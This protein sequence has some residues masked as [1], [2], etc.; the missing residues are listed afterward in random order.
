MIRRF[1]AI[2]VSVLLLTGCGAQSV[3]ENPADSLELIDAAETEMIT[4]EPAETGITNEIPDET[5]TAPEAAAAD[6]SST[7]KKTSAARTATETVAD[8]SVH[9]PDGQNAEEKPAKKKRKK[10]DLSD[11]GIDY[12]VFTESVESYTEPLKGKWFYEGEPPVFKYKKLTSPDG[13]MIALD[14]EGR[15]VRFRN[16]PEIADAPL[17]EA[18][19]DCAP[20]DKLNAFFDAVLPDQQMIEAEYAGRCSDGARKNDFYGY[21]EMLPDDSGFVQAELNGDSTIQRVDITYYY[22]QE[23]IRKA[24]YDREIDTIL[25]QFSMDH[26][27]TVEEQYF[28]LIDGYVYGEYWAVTG[29]DGEYG[30]FG[31][32]VRADHDSVPLIKEYKHASLE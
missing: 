10:N 6:A 9:D 5:Q 7:T 12:S 13:M 22:P 14:E 2:T 32:I 17:I 15:I 27:G 26:E 4:A 31:F 30:D 23:K 18:E 11:A 24:D 28:H 3:Q 25:K 8:A 1:A 20:L 21:V 19:N 29:F 16:T